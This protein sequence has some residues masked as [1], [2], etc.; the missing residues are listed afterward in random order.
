MKSILTGIDPRMYLPG[1]FDFST[2]V[3]KLFGLVCSVGSG[4]I[5]GTEGSYVHIMSIIT[6]H[7]LKTMMYQGFG[8]R[9]NARIQLLAAACAVGVA[10]TFSSPIGGVLFSMEVTST[11]Y[12]MS[13]YMKAFI[14]SVS[15]AAMLHI[16]LNLAESSSAESKNTIL[17]TTFPESPFRMWEIP[18]FLLL[19]ALIGAITTAMVWLL[20]KVAEQ[21]KVC[22]KSSNKWLVFFVKWID[23]VLIALLTAA[24]TFFPG[25]FIQ[26]LSMENLTNLFTATEL[27]SMWLFVSKY[28]TLALV[29]VI[30]LLL[31]PLCITLKLPT[32]VWLPSFIAG[33]ALGRL[34]GE[35]MTAFLPFSETTLIPGIYSLAGAAACTA[36]STRTVS[37]AVITLEITG[38]MQVMVPIFCAALASIAVS[39]LWTETSVYDTLLLV[40]GMPYLPLLDFDSDL[41][42][43]AIIEPHLVYIPKRTSVARLLLVIQRLPGQEIPVVQSESS[44]ILLGVVTAAQIKELI[45]NY[46]VENDIED[47][48]VDLGEEVKSTS[49]GLSW[50]TLRDKMSSNRIGG[51]NGTMSYDQHYN[52]ISLN[53]QNGTHALPRGTVMTNLNHHNGGVQVP[54]LMNDVKMMEL[55]RQGWSDNKKDLLDVPIK[56]TKDNFCVIRP[57]AMTVSSATSLDDLHMIFTMLRCDH[58]F[59]C[60][61]GALMGVVTTRGL[62][63]AGNYNRT[64]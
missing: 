33:A 47:V 23:P 8:T 36:G 45:R 48:E 26:T 59:V 62:L 61:Q 46:Y 58:C 52:S 54:F 12:L 28:Y 44:R 25:S 11:Y 32:G 41:A 42:V 5:V 7:I 6:H 1:Y 50:A 4:L 27:D 10:S 16:T 57:M 38:A 56:I 21:R 24:A 55:M 30:Y 39:N 13:N 2:L 51:L 35:A 3:A 40:S 63:Q 34:F 14:S 37:A 60:D 53:M 20:R 64:S 22:W 17:A 9:Q 31:L 29:G 49:G 15:A 18:L 43:G 19:G